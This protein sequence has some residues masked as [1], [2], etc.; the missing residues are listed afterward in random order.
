MKVSKETKV[1]IELNS[2]WELDALVST[3]LSAPDFGEED[4]ESFIRKLLE[5]LKK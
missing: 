2:K 1:T 5:E 4:R 3:L